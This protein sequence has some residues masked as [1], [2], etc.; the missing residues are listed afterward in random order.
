M[1]KKVILGVVILVMMF[2]AVVYAETKIENA[3]S[4][5]GRRSCKYVLATDFN[6]FPGANDHAGANH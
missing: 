1:K 5:D 3:I 4:N 2:S 6:R